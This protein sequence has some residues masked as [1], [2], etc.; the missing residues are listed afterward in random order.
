VKVPVNAGDTVPAPVWFRPRVPAPVP[1][2]AVT[3]QLV[4]LPL[5]VVIA[6]PVSPL[7]TRPKAAAVTFV[8]LRLK[9]TF[10][11][12]VVVMDVCEHAVVQ[13]MA[14]TTVAGVV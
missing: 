13:V 4:P 1:T 9:V 5:T 11:D 10:H 14:V 3:V 8:T 2:F 7:A 12:T 6:D